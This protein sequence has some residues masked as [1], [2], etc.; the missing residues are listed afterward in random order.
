MTCQGGGGGGQKFLILLSKQTTKRGGGGQKLPILRRHS[1]WTVP[2]LFEWFS[3]RISFF[4]SIGE[5]KMCLTI[6]IKKSF[7]FRG[8]SFKNY[9]DK[10]WWVGGQKMLIFVHV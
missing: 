6:F 2:N 1:L 3:L 8:S 7:F 5:K 4:H 9:L 10:M